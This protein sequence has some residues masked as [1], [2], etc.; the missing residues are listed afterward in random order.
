MWIFMDK[1]IYYK[2]SFFKL[3][4]TIIKTFKWI[5]ARKPDL[6]CNNTFQNF[7]EYF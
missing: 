4:L 1:I 5:P 3:E 7:Q 6:E 2:L